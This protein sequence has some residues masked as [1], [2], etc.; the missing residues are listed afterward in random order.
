[1]IRDFRISE[2]QTV[3][4]RAEA[5][6]VTNSMRPYMAPLPNGDNSTKLGTTQFGKIYTDANTSGTSSV[7]NNQLVG[8]GG[9]VIQFALKYVF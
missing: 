9:R 1:L 8:S 3:Q 7:S 4:F 2:R 5:F 6:N